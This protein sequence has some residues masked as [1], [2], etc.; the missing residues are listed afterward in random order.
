MKNI[1]SLIVLVCIF[2][3]SA[4]ANEVDDYVKSLIPEI[5]TWLSHDLVVSGIKSQNE[6]HASLTQTDIDKLDKQWRAEVSGA[7]KPLVDEVMSKDVSGFLK[8][9]KAQS[10]GKYTEIFLMDNRGLNVGQSDITSDYWQGDE[11]K[12][13]STF[14]KGADAIHVSEVEFDESTQTYQAQLSLPV[15]DSTGQVIGAVTVGIS[16]EEL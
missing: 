5:K 15:V 3:L 12:W 10:E 13:K 11:A 2:P 8:E 4:L 9:K 1:L 7:A 16:I 14:L 6:K